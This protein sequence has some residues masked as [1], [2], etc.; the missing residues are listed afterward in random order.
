MSE[1][2]G[3]HESAAEASSADHNAPD[4]DTAAQDTVDQHNPT[5][6]AEETLHTSAT[7]MEVSPASAVNNE[8]DQAGAEEHTA[9]HNNPSTSTSTSRSEGALAPSVTARKTSSAPVGTTSA[10][11]TAANVESSAATSSSSA[12]PSSVVPFVP[13]SFRSELYFLMVRFLESDKRTAPTADMLAKALERDRLLTPRYDWTGAAH[14]KTFEDV[15]S[16]S[17]PVGADHLIRLCYRMSESLGEPAPGVRTLLGRGAGAARRRT[18]HPMKTLM[19]SQMGLVTPLAAP[20]PW[21]LRLAKQMRKLRRTLGHLSSVYCLL[22]DRTGKFAFTGADD[23]LVKC[24][25][26]HDGRLVHTFRGASSEISDLAISHDNRLLAA[27]SCD[28]VI[29]VWCLRTASPVAVLTKHTAMITAV[30]FCPRG[31]YLASTSG[32]GTVSFWRFSYN[33]HE[34][35]IFDEAPTR[36][37]EKIR[38]GQA[39]MICASFSPGGVF[40]CVGSADHHVRVYQLNGEEP[41]R[42][43]EEEAHDDRVDSIQWSNTPA[44]L[45]FVSGSKDGTARI[46]TYRGRR[47]STLVLNM[48]TGDNTEPVVAA[49]S[50]NAPASSSSSRAPSGPANTQQP[51]GERVTMVAWTLDDSVVI[52]AVSDR[53]LR[54]WDANSGALR[55]T[56]TG[57]EDE[58]FVLEPHPFARNLLLSAAHDG[59]IIV[60]DLDEGR[61]L[62]RHKN[63]VEDL[64]GHGAVYDAKWTPDGLTV[65][66]TDSHGHVI[67]LGHGSAER[68]NKLPVELFFHTDYRPLLR[69]S[70]HNVVDEQTQVP[71]HL[72]PPPFLVDSEGSPYPGY[73]QVSFR[74]TKIH[75]FSRDFSL[76]A[77][78]RQVHVPGRERMGEGEAMLPMD[79][80]QRDHQQEQEQRQRQDGRENRRSQNRG[81]VQAQGALQNVGLPQGGRVQGGL[82][83]VLPAARAQNQAPVEQGPAAPLV[84]VAEPAAPQDGGPVAGPS[85]G[86]PDVPLDP[87]AVAAAVQHSQSRRILTEK[88]C[89]GREVQDHL[90]HMADLAEAEVAAFMAQSD[91]AA[92]AAADHDYA[93]AMAAKEKARKLA[94]KAGGGRRNR[95][96]RAQ[97]DEEEE[98]ESEPEEQAADDA[99]ARDSSS[100]DESDLSSMESTTEEE[101]SDDHSDWGSGPDEDKESSPQRK[102]KVIT[103]DKKKAKKDKKRSAAQKCRETLLMRP[104]DISEDYMPSPWLSESIP[105]KTPYFPQI[106]DILVYFK[107]VSTFCGFS[108]YSLLQHYLKCAF[109]LRA[110]KNT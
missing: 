58:V 51:A 38:P 89:N 103:P 97:E 56:L 94:A 100:F 64:G 105:K 6:T 57:H 76:F 13:D 41:K 8:A 110:T 72:L 25:R 39:Q 68:Y 79:Q 35:A 65:C 104:S 87:V 90:G 27:G 52:T 86:R 93:R 12:K 18:G 88:D 83:D 82:G 108:Y 30:N 61:A 5:T 55:R 78:L 2:D 96:R 107:Q 14:A 44:K 43:L 69:D 62:F 21:H 15:R 36:Y 60:W 85:V 28:K 54:L 17:G 98:E 91:P 22:F 109:L 67:F 45:R 95:A 47:W 20:R 66:A 7:P 74:I 24:W 71:P 84:A 99:A 33:E 77:F 1:D 63:V 11:S 70:F 92:V 19:H 80:Q 49:K 53:S 81:P 29:R 106:G 23:L 34:Q 102:A 46:W 59:Q 31:Q 26:V 37:H 42:I 9:D 101:M 10:G 4:Q 32:D 48:R 73:I 50:G 75:P 40:F 16:E 3:Q